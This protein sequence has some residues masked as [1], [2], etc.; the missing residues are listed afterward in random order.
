M[1]NKGIE[2]YVIN[3]DEE[4]T[5]NML[6]SAIVADENDRSFE[7]ICFDTVALLPEQGGFIMSF[8][9]KLKGDVTEFFLSSLKELI[10]QKTGLPARFI[11]TFTE[12]APFEK[13]VRVLWK[14]FRE[15][16]QEKGTW[17]DGTDVN[18]GSGILGIKCTNEFVAGKI[19]EQKTLL[20]IMKKF[21]EFYGR[22]AEVRVEF[23]ET[24]KAGQGEPE[25]AKPS[26]KITQEKSKESK[27]IT[28]DEIKGEP[29]PIEQI[30]EPRRCII[31]GRSFVGEDAVRE[32]RSKKG[33]YIICFYITDDTDSIK[34]IA[35][36]DEGD[37][38]IDEVKTM[39]HVRVSAEISYD[40]REGELTARV[41]RIKKIPAPLR[42]DM[43]AAGEKRIELHAHTK[44]SA[45]DGL[46][47]IED[48]IKTAINWG[49]EA[50]AITD[51]GVVHSFPI[52]F[53]AIKKMKS[54]IKLIFGMEGY[55]ID[56]KDG[57]AI[58]GQDEGKEKDKKLKP[59]HITLLV[60][61][62]VGLKNLYKLVSESHINYFYKKANIPRSVLMK[63]REGLII[64][65]AC[66]L[67]EVFQSFVKN[68]SSEKK[69][70]VAG[71][72]DY[73]EIMPDTNNAFMIKEGMVKDIEA[74]HVLNHEII[75]LGWK[76]NKP[77]VATGD[78]HFLNPKD[79]KYRE[80]LM[81][82]MGFD[83]AD[84]DL[85][86]HTTDEMLEE[87]KYLGED[88]AKEV[89]IKNPKKIAAMIEHGIK[90]VPDNLH[91]P[92]IEDAAKKIR[93]ASWDRA[94][95]LYG[96]RM[97][98]EVKARASRELE[99]IIGNNYAVLYLIAKE[100]V[101]KSNSDGYIV[102]SRGSVGSSFVAYLCGISEV[103]PLQ[104][105]HLCQ[106][107]KHMEFVNTDL[108]GV[109]LEEKMCPECG[110]KMLRDGFNIP[111]E[112][113][114]GFKGDK[115]PDIDLNFSGEY[116]SKIHDFLI[117]MFG[118]DKVFRAGT[119]S[120]L[121]QKA[122]EKDFMNKYIEKTG[123]VLKNAEK[124]RL[125]L[126]CIDVK[127]STG[128][129]P[130]GLMLV[131][132]DKEIYD[133]T[134]IQYSPDKS[135]ITTHFDYHYIHDTLVKIDALGHE[136]PTSLK[137]ICEGLKIKVEDIPIDDKKTMQIFSGLKVLG[138]NP[139]NYDPAIG[140][141]GVPEYGTKFTRDMLNDTKPKTFAELVYIAGLSHGT[142][143]WLG[144]AKD[145]IDSKKATLKEV[146]SVR[147][148]IMNYLINKGL[149]KST[150]FK[151][152]ESVRKGKGLTP[153]DEKI[154][155]DHKVPDWYI[156]SCKKIKYM[157]PKAHAVAYAIMSVRIAYMKVHHPLYFYADYF[158]RD[159]EGFD[160]DFISYDF[161]I[162]KRK[163]REGKMN[164]DQDKKEKDRMRVLEVLM[165][166]K[167]R[168]MGI[169]NVDLYES[170][171]LRFTVKNEKIVPPL[172][173]VPSLGQKVALGI[174]LERA[175]GRFSSAEDL[176]KRTKVNKNVLEFI[177]VN[178]IA[179]GLPESDQAVLF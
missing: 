22:D 67:G 65:S 140:T 2:A 132:M 1:E 20:L 93:E 179:E 89:V 36:A 38:L 66:Y 35:F 154:M 71:L 13:L 136:L 130:G 145:L 124:T 43:A 127:R 109:D 177:R 172:I 25:E 150:A 3:I 170:D 165:E 101:N 85:F 98:H 11:Y 126:G 59:W 113:F 175:K 94:Y 146:I 96:D 173:I 167:E 116:Q 104:A 143:V 53:G 30:H 97:L 4:E 17:F 51:H 49:H 86:F 168:K 69:E 19:S 161:D 129:H 41:K 118:K 141:L 155:K 64:G 78:V 100:M 117:N 99:A 121:Q 106:S 44:M 27:I 48:Y 21:R 135:S 178:K 103:N 83:E 28:N 151:I 123:A 134:P 157:F 160:Y 110:K 54:N 138:L 163:V 174:A 148:D 87:F 14:F 68:D 88:T 102:G 29:T 63:H 156:D 122:V 55:L 58:R 61:N 107:C 137:H 7:N 10:G 114:M 108:A 31:E 176:S 18:F 147:D 158:N 39:G 79:K 6:R 23:D 9:L 128:Q 92:S 60:K 105:H 153:E 34:A 33:T 169:V 125:A 56:D 42:K 50:V 90:P 72:Y 24:L 57:D 45:M 5:K 46:M 164:K 52:A 75:E 171:P 111:F 76:L 91:P 47:N 73:F 70:Q 133:F 16:L 119:L 32:L 142:D 62:Y 159:M 115:V 120:T 74:L 37:G 81:L 15:E 112:T 139:E 84:A 26:I 95:E 131:P 40:D 80:F 77:V 12:D 82:A 162:A 8:T 166:M 144:N 149:E 152:T